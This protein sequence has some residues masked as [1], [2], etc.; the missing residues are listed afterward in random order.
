MGKMDYQHGEGRPDA[1]SGLMV[2]NNGSGVN[3][4]ENCGNYPVDRK[5][6]RV[7]HKKPPL[8]PSDVGGGGRPLRVGKAKKRGSESQEILVGL[9]TR[10]V[11]TSLQDSYRDDDVGEGDTG[12]VGDYGIAGHGGGDFDYTDEASDIRSVEE[13]LRSQRSMADVFY[14]QMNGEALDNADVPIVGGTGLGG[15]RLPLVHELE[16]F[17][18]FD[19]DGDL[20]ENM[21][22]AAFDTDKEVP[23]VR[24]KSSAPHASFSSSSETEPSMS[25]S[26]DDSGSQ[27]SNSRGTDGEEQLSVEEIKRSV[28]EHIPDN[29]REK[30]PK[31]A[32]NLIFGSALADATM[33]PDQP[34]TEDTGP[35]DPSGNE[36]RFSDPKVDELVIGACTTDDEDDGMS[37]ISDITGFTGANMQFDKS[38]GES[39]YIQ[40][41]SSFNRSS[42]NESRFGLRVEEDSVVQGTVTRLHR[43]GRDS[44]ADDRGQQTVSFQNVQVRYYQRILEVNPGVTNGPAIGIGWN[45]MVGEQISVD[46]WEVQRGTIRTPDDL[47]IPRKKREQILQDEGY[48]QK[49]IAE[50]M[51]SITKAKNQRRTT[52]H[53]L[54]MKPV[55]EAVESAARRVKGLLSFGKKKGL[56]KK[57][58]DSVKKKEK[59]KHKDRH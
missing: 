26:R 24:S 52:I 19:D 22:F 46:Q 59:K 38:F 15:T 53:N 9:I 55:E 35:T 51:R 49:D 30:I 12:V 48:S 32:W 58:K 5:K 45:Y 1:N 6:K 34:S 39:Q 21:S 20:L 43:R 3:V 18:N 36:R 31:D 57:Q 14:A 16:E 28:M 13:S 29:I 2:S 37:V 11:L 17:N 42:N 8:P 27:E 54:G 4:N 7:A 10:E 50:A 23:P 44:R 25:V 33:K 56:I 41:E 47:V 40:F